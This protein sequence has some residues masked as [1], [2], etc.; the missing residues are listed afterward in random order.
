MAEKISPPTPGHIVPTALHSEMQRSYLEYAM[1]VIVGRALPDAKD[2]LKPVH[3]RILYAMY[4]LGL[5][6][7]RPYRKCARVV[8]DVLGKYHPHGDQSVYDALVRLVQ[9]FSTRYPLLDGHGNFGSIDND[10]AAAMRY[11]E[12]RLAG[13]AY[14]GMLMDIGE[15]TVDFCPNFDESQQE[16]KVLPVQLPIL[17]LNG[18][19]GIAVGMATNIPPHNLGEVVDGLIALINNPQL[20]DRQLWEIIPGP[21]FP[22]GGEILDREGIQQAYG[23]GR[24]IIPLRGVVHQETLY[25]RARKRKQKIKALVVT[26]LP[27]QVNKAAWIEKVAKLVNE[28]KLTGISDIRDESDRQGMRVVVELKRDAN[29]QE[30]LEFLYKKTPLQQNFG[31]ILLALVDNQPQQLSLRALLNTFLD[32]REQ[33]LHRKYHHELEEKRD[34]LHLLNGFVT[35]LNHLDPLIDILRQAADGT[36]AKLRLQEELGLSLSQADAILGMPMRRITA[37]EQQKLLDEQQ[38]LLQEIQRLETLLSD[39]HELLKSLK[40]ELRA[41]KRRFGDERRTKIHGPLAPKKTPPPT[42][43]PSDRPPE[44]LDLFG[45]QPAP[46][47]PEKTVKKRAPKKTKPPLELD[48]FPSAVETPNAVAVVTEQGHFYWQHQGEDLHHFPSIHQDQDRVR[49]CG[50]IAQRSPL[51]VVTQEGKAYPIDLGELAHGNQGDRRKIWDFLPASV[52]KTQP[53]L[54]GFFFLP[55]DPHQWELLLLT[56]GGKMKR[57]PLQELADLSNRG[58]A[59]IKLKTPDTLAHC[60]VVQEGQ[61]VA[62]AVSSGRILRYGIQ[63]REIP[64]MG[65]TAQ[66]N[67]ALKLRY[68]EQIVGCAS[69]VGASQALLLVT[70]EG[71]GKKLNIQSLRRSRVGDLG[72]HALQFK[73]RDDQLMA[74]AVLDPHHRHQLHTNHQHF[75]L[76]LDTL[77]IAG[78]DGAGEKLL[79]LQAG[80]EIVRILSMP[81][82]DDP[83][84]LATEGENPAPDQPKKTNGD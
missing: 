52:A 82:P 37:L 9:D 66:G 76:E 73:S 24:G 32:F 39:R 36:T 26:E 22:T 10:P 14:E 29:P 83:E 19:S 15:E 74:I 11:T 55:P 35:A 51:V 28:G 50:A 64:L 45:T 59:L 81:S 38:A 4:E 69:M 78:K 17:L 12:T 16:P 48:L 77:A 43:D 2:G 57:L 18:C 84:P 46:T 58:L 47:P 20:S 75:T 1:S 8:G 56:A 33:T 25:H 23:E 3:R 44:T 54:T 21:D 62:I 53:H 6:P 5:T 63:D 30:V 67:Q 13:V 61:E 71:Y 79:Q 60:C 27:Y 41:L 40:K 34:R 49:W 7:D 31:A 80:E 42:P 68:R 72:S 70:K 65:R